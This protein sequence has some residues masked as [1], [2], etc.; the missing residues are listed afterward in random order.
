MN[1]RA[2]ARGSGAYVIGIVAII[3][4]LMGS[5]I[6]SMVD[7]FMQGLMDSQL[8]SAD[9]V[10]GQNALG[11]FAA[12]AGFAGAAILIAILIQVY[13]DTRQPV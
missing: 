6:L 7:P 5:L 13:I 8:W 3:A 11:W 1:N 12:A 10:E 2:Q 4:F 9:T